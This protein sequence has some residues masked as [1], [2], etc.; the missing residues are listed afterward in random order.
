MGIIFHNTDEK[1][2]KVL[3]SKFIIFEAE[4]EKNFKQ[5]KMVA[6]CFIG[7]VNE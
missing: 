4:E 5:K 6:Q 7:S 3:P 1:T 2:R